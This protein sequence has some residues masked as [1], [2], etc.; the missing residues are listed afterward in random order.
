MVPSVSVLYSI[1]RRLPDSEEA[2]SF[3]L[4]HIFLETGGKGVEGPDLLFVEGPLRIGV[5]AKTFNC[6]GRNHFFAINDNKHKHLVRQCVGYMASEFCP[7]WA[8]R[9][10]V[11]S[12]IPYGDV[13]SW[14]CD[15]LRKNS[16]GKQGT[17]SRNLEIVDAMRL[18][19]SSSYDI[20]ASRC[21]SHPQSKVWQT[22]LQTGKGSVMTYLGELLPKTAPYLPPAQE[23]L[24]RTQ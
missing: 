7:L 8:R 13:S 21:D 23:D 6:Q 5:D 18:Y 1:V 9:G 15:Q 12:L 19:T 2:V 3:I 16:K 24:R 11:T 22:A 4:N 17:P 10:C 14:D 20:N